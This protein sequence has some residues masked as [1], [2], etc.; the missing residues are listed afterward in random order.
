MLIAEMEAH[1]AQLMAIETRI[2]AMESNIDF[3]GIFHVCEAS[4][5]HITPAINFRKRREL[6]PETPSLR[7]FDVVWTYA[8]PLFEHST[9]ESTLTFVRST[10]L[11]AKHVN[12]YLEATEAAL[13]REEAARIL[14]NYIEGNPGTL[15]RTAVQQLG[16]DRDVAV[17]ILDVW[18][19]LAVVTRVPEKNTHK[20]VLATRLEEETA[21]ICPS[22][23]SRVKARKVH[24]LQPASCPKCGERDF[25]HICAVSH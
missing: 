15:E 6:A 11:L 22:C 20:L 23:G 1:H 13:K 2:S 25:F 7:A 8:P 3:P 21:A 5:Q 12:G 10:R 19:R 4:F 16:L 24:L 9:L 14:W 17:T 18:A